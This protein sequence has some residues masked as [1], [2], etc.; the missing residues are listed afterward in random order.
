M[1]TSKNTLVIPTDFGWSDVGSW[2]ALWEVSEKDDQGIA[3]RNREGL[4]S[5]NSRNSLVYSPKKLV[6]LV[7]VTDLIV[8]ETEDALL[9]CKRGASQEVKKVV[10]TLEEEKRE[11][12]L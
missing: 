3:A 10:E 9:I 4:I 5:V 12:Y 8:V 7:E 11:E 2:D 6:A 1:E